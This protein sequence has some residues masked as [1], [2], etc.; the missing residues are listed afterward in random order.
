M[1]RIVPGEENDDRVQVGARKATHPMLGRIRTGIAEHLPRPRRHALLELL[2][3]GCKRFLV[4]SERAKSVPGESRR[5]PP[6]VLIDAVTHRRCRINLLFDC[7][8][9]SAATGSIAK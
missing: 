8:H 7:R 9:P 6:L 5:N 1:F 3:E 2:R 4:Q